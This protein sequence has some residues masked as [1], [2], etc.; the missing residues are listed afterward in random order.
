MVADCAGLADAVAGRPT[1][2]DAPTMPAR[3]ST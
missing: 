1:Q 2:V 3:L